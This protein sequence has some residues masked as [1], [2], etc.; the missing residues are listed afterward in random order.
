VHLDEAKQKMRL[1]KLGKKRGNHS[2][3]HIEKIRLSQVGRK[4]TE[5]HKE[6]LRL[7]KIGETRIAKIVTCPH[8]NKQ[9]GSAGMTRYHFDNCKIRNINA[10]HK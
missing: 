6:K 1:A 2:L 3:E 5:E 4:F 7:A 9:G 10:N 8:C